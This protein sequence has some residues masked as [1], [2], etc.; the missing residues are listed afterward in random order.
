ML[1]VQKILTPMNTAVNSVHKNWERTLPRSKMVY[2]STIKD[3]AKYRFWYLYGRFHPLVRD[4]ALGLGVVSH[5]GRQ[6]FLIGKIVPPYSIKDVV[7]FLIDRGYGNHFIAWKDEGEVVSLRKVVGFSH[8][9]HLRIFKDGEIRGHYEYTP[10]CYPILHYK[11]VDQKD[12]RDEFS[13]LLKGMI[14]S[15]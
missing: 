14:E 11:A 1:R 13:A 6:N 7:D 9:Y 2:P 4:V 3:R 15:V 12:C 10:E 5:S 8:Q